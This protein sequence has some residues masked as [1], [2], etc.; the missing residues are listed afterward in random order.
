MKKAPSNSGNS[1]LALM[2]ASTALSIG[3]VGSTLD[4]DHK[5]KK[6]LFVFAAIL[7]IYALG[8]ITFSLLK[9]KPQNKNDDNAGLM[10]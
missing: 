6:V 8:L 5:L 7:L 1:F 4:E 3:T 2:M 9:A 10:E